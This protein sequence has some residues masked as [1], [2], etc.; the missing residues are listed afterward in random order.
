MIEYRAL[1]E[2]DI[3]CDCIMKV[4][5]SSSYLAYKLALLMAPEWMSKVVKVYNWNSG[6]W[7]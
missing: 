1:Y 7:K 3:Q 4:F 6:T 2:A 5:M